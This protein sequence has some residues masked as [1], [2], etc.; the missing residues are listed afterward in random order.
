MQ[1]WM[2]EKERRPVSYGVVLAHTGTLLRVDPGVGGWSRASFRE[3]RSAT[4]V[5][6]FETRRR[7]GRASLL[8]RSSKGSRSFLRPDGTSAALPRRGQHWVALV[9]LVAIAQGCAS[10]PSAPSAAGGSGGSGGSGG[11]TQTDSGGGGQGGQA[12]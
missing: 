8:D 3:P 11:D 2:P 9:P 1:Q 12:G 5:D 10:A 7:P 6:M 4:M